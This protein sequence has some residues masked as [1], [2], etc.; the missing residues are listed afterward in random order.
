[1]RK[2]KLSRRM[3]AVI[4]AAVMVLGGT[5]WRIPRQLIRSRDP[6]F[7][8]VF[9]CRTTKLTKMIITGQAVSKPLH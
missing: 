2:Q 9:P 6:Q 4:L 8:W 5:S 1:M 3:M 7:Y